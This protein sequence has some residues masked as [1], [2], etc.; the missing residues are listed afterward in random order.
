MRL[1][2]QLNHELVM[3]KNVTSATAL[4]GVVGHAA[5]LRMTR[6]TGCEV[7]S[8]CPVMM[9][10]AIWSVN[11]INSHKPPPQASITCGRLEGVNATPATITTKVA[12]SAKTKAS[13]THRSVQAVNASATVSY[14]HL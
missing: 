13:G 6:P 10:R 2:P 14:T 1:N 3:A 7:A 9:M 5:T 8:T 4:R 11:G 12:R